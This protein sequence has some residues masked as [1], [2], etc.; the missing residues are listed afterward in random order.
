[1]YYQNVHIS[2]LSFFSL[3]PGKQIIPDYVV[4]CHSRAGGDLAISVPSG[5][6]SSLISHLGENDGTG[7]SLRIHHV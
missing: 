4:F 3:Q 2:N 1:M 6:K 5:S 7:D